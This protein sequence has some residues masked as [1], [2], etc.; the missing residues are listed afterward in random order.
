MAEMF[1][2]EKSVAEVS[3]AKTSVAEVSLAKMSVVENL[4]HSRF[5]II[6]DAAKQIQKCYSIQ[7][8]LNNILFINSQV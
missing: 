7:I 6:I 8:G 2:A 5:S 1:L 3:L 4:I